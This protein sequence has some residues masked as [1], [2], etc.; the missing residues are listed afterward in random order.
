MRTG[1]LIPVGKA[2]GE[3]AQLPIEGK[4]TKWIQAVPYG[5]WDHPMFGVTVFNKDNASEMKQNFLNNVS[6]TGL[7]TDFEHGLDRAKGSKASGR[8][9]DMDV[10]DDGLYWRVEFTEEA[11]K[12][13]RDGAWNYFSPEWYDDWTTPM[14]ESKFAGKEFNHVPSGGALTNKPWIKDMIPVNA[15]SEAVLEDNKTMLHKEMDE[16]HYIST[17]GGNTWEVVGSVADWE[18]SEP[19]SGPTPRTDEDDKSGDNKDSGS[20]RDSPPPAFEP[21]DNSKEGSEVKFTKEELAKMGL[22]EDATDEQIREA[23]LVAFSEAVTARKANADAAKDKAFS[24]QFPEEHAEL[25]RQREGRIEGEAKKFSMGFVRQTDAE[26]NPTTKGFSAL[27]ISKI[28]DTHKLFS[29]GKVE[30]GMKL[31]SETLELANK[32]TNVLDYGNIGS[33]LETPE[34]DDKVV[35]S[36]PDGIAKQFAEAVTA[37]QNAAGGASKMSWG[38]AISATA[39]EKPELAK[40]YS[41]LH[42]RPS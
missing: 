12:E 30:D 29:Q 21:P 31:F 27:V 17:D 39:A 33:T 2:F 3:L 1:M 15:F 16:K 14:G 20:R 37:T 42:A 28:A 4:I 32:A 10:K 7:H 8:V 38:D 25:M 35:A 24:E 26:G 40:A 13:I 11:S 5:S 18:H 41:E 19:G 9:L 36:D 22:P 23:T 34:T 6:G